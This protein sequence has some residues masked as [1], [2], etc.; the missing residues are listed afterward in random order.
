MSCVTG[1]GVWSSN[2]TSVVSVNTNGI[3]NGMS[4]GNATISYTVTANGCSKAATAS[5]TV[6]PLPLL[7]TITQ[8]N[9]TLTCSTVG[10]ASYNWYRNN[11]LLTPS[12]TIPKLKITQ[13]GTYTVEV[14]GTNQ[15]TSLRSAGFSASLTGIK[16]NKTDIQYS[17]VPNPNF[18]SFEIRLTS[19]SNTIYQLKLYNVNGQTIFS[20]EMS[21]KIGQNTRQLNIKGIEKGIYF[22]SLIGDDGIS[23]Q[24]ILI[25]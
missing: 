22:L 8:R 11:I 12:T 21:V 19:I 4:A 18:G 24:N 16:N 7:P 23:T 13:S 10:G 2:A 5:V 17:I 14:V 9:D 6:K 20:E 15:C 3:V 25:Q 1:G